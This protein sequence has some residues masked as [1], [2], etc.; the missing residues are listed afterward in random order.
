MG[1]FSRRDFLRISGMTAA[2]LAAAGPLGR[3]PVLAQSAELSVQT[4]GHFITSLNP[5]LESMT[6][7][8]ASKNDASIQWNYAGFDAMLQT[9]STAAATGAGPDIVMF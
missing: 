6:A 8:W 4:W 2:G 5:L 9:I 3:L 1:K 7:D